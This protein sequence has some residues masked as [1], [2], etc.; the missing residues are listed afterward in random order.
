MQDAV[1]RMLVDKYKPLRT[2]AIRGADEKLRRAPPR[3]VPG[4]IQLDDS[5]S[6][7]WHPSPN[8]PAPT[9]EP[10]IPATEGHKPWLTTFKV[11]SHVSSVRYGQFPTRTP[12]HTRPAPA[13][14]Q[15]ERARK[16]EREARK[17]LQ[18]AGRLTRARES[19]LDYRLGI[20]SQQARPNPVSVKGWQGLV[21]ERIEVRSMC[22]V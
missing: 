6:V 9:R 10:L 19:T 13:D 14:A 22:V 16:K 1:L 18:N 21:E 2:G 15:D 20:K 4:P 12:S 17:H 11:P 3:V 7:D 5:F 8:A